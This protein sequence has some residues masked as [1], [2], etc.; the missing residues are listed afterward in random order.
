[1]IGSKMN[2]R[3]VRSHVM[4]ATHLSRSLGSLVTLVLAVGLAHPV[5]AQTGSDFKPPQD[6]D[7]SRPGSATLPAPRTGSTQDENKSA[8]N[9]L[10]TR[11]AFDLLMKEMDSLIPG[12]FEEESAQKKA[13]EDAVTAFQLRD[14]NRVIQ[15]LKAQAIADPDFPPADVL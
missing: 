3:T 14:A 1:M 15:L 2:A 10:S 8:A 13:V 4:T 6:I 9:Q 11:Q 5:I 7:G 12:D